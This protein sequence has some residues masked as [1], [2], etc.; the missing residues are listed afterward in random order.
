MKTEDNNTIEI[1][2]LTKRY[3][4]AKRDALSR[5]SLKVR[6]GE[7]Y[8]FLGPN[9]A[10]KSTAIRTLLNFLQPTSGSAKILG[11]DI[12]IDSVK[13]RKHIG[14]LSGDMAIYPKMTGRQFLKFLS[15]IQAPKNKKIISRLAKDL[16]ADLSKKMGDLSRGNRQKIGLIQAFMHEPD[17]FI[18]DEPTSGLDPL[19]QEVFYSM[20]DQAKSRGASIFMSSHILTEVQKTCDRIGF[21]RDGVLVSERNI[22]QMETEA[23]QTFE[24]TFN[25]KPPITE[26]KK[27]KGVK[28]VSLVREGVVRLHMHGD[29]S[30]LFRVLARHNIKRVESGE[31]NLEDEFMSFYEPGGKT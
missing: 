12:V 19:M 20:L 22:S 28:K 14:Y 13:I 18:L 30:G 8:G 15:E 16:K 4:G 9:G 23:S 25:S 31:L 10:G 24:V 27:I 2:S 21:I 3:P 5:V 11:M 29:L 7:V 17:V 6:R 26:I 1:N